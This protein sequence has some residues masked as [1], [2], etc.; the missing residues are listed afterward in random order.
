M[1]AKSKLEYLRKT[2]NEKI[3]LFDRKRQKNKF[4][5]LGLKLFGAAAAAAITVLLGLKLDEKPDVFYS[6]IALVLGAGI[7]VV[8][9]WDAFFNH[10]VLWVRFTATTVELRC[11]LDQLEYSAA[12]SDD[13]PS[14]EELDSYQERLTEILNSTNSEWEEFRRRELAADAA[15]SH[16]KVQVPQ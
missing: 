9:T 12:G 1:K 8:N 6:N 10:K 11:L 5:A 13:E 4:L 7:T 2:I 3:V 14:K 16:A 15:S